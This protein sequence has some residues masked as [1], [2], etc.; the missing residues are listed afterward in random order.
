[1]EPTACETRWKAT[2][3]S[4]ESNYEELTE[5]NLDC[6]EELELLKRR[7]ASKPLQKNKQIKSKPTPGPR[8]PR[9]RSQV[10]VQVPTR[11]FCAPEDIRNGRRGDD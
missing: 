8:D 10:E 3:S 2:E 7:G 11:N 5:R 1:M 6:Q 4:F 9:I